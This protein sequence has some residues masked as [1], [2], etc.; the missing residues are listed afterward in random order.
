MGTRSP[1]SSRDLRLTVSQGLARI[2]HRETLSPDTYSVYEYDPSG[3]EGVDAYIIDTG[4]N[5]NHTEFEGRA[6][7]GITIP[8]NDV[9]E[10]RVG[11]GTH[12]AGIV[13]SR[14]YGVA[15]AV[16]LIAVKV[17]DPNGNGHLSDVIAGVLWSA[18]RA[19]AK[20][21]AAK[22]EYAATGRTNHKGSV[23]NLPLGGGKSLAL[24]TSIKRAFDSGLV[25]AVPA[26][27]LNEDA[28]N[29]SPAGAGKAVTVGASTDGDQMAVFSNWGRC[30][31]IFAPGEYY[32][33]SSWE[34]LSD[35][36]LNRSK[37]SLHLYRKRYR[38][39]H[40][41][42]HRL[43]FCLHRRPP[44]LLRL[45]L[46]IQVLQSR[47]FCFRSLSRRSVGPSACRS[48][49][50]LFRPHHPSLLD[51]VDASPSRCP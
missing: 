3:G 30:V 28:C 33:P 22:A 51:V 25:I 49:H 6:S 45:Y 40:L 11:H 13:G 46:P 4:I 9:D 5:I 47:C 12:C 42:R 24:D 29:S 39:Y 8:K 43:V 50:L 41:V 44:C 48:H 26:G 1:L 2:S 15:K 37:H 14:K 18:E 7:W 34:L 17:L 16:N 35:T 31:D 19:A 21:A 23:A 27:Y 38:Q 32:H 10:D 20:L 36:S